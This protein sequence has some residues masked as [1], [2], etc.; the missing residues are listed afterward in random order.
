MSKY[1]PTR[2]DILMGMAA[3]PL[4]QQIQTPQPADASICFMSAEE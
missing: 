2:R 4:L 1:L 3:A